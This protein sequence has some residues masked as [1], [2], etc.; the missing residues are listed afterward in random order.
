MDN[1]IKCR[2]RHDRGTIGQPHKA[3]E[4]WCSEPC[5]EEKDRPSQATQGKERYDGIKTR[6][7]EKCNDGSFVMRGILYSLELNRE[8][9][10]GE[11]VASWTYCRLQSFRLIPPTSRID[12]P[13]YRPN[14]VDF[15]I[16][17]AFRRISEHW[18]LAVIKSMLSKQAVD[19]LVC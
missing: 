8:S 6:M 7:S 10:E 17:C 14:R 2:R 3:D 15:I 9:G 5:G 1:G 19:S 18:S 12:I 13:V 11:E 16:G 4:G